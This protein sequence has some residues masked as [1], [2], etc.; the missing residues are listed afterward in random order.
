MQVSWVTLQSQELL[1][2]HRK[3]LEPKLTISGVPYAFQKWPRL[4]VPAIFSH[5]LEQFLGNVILE[6]MQRWSQSAVLGLPVNF[7]L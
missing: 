5:W 6:K 4:S 2:G 1:Q 3:V 7:I